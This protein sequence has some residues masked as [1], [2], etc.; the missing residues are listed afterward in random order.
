MGEGCGPVP[1]SAG[2][3]VKNGYWGGTVGGASGGVLWQG[4]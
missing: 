3:M 1:A 2:V 4:L